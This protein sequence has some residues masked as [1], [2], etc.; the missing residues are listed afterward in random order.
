MINNL[1]MNEIDGHRFIEWQTKSDFEYQAEKGDAIQIS[2][3]NISYRGILSD[4]DKN[5]FY[6]RTSPLIRV[7][8]I[9]IRYDDVVNIECL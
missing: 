1:G 9:H 7:P 3:K 2:C 6:L 4:F 8:Q 5:G